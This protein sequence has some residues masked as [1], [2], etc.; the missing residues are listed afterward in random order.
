MTSQTDPAAICSASA[1]CDSQSA[2][3]SWRLFPGPTLV[4]LVGSLLIVMAARF[5][6]VS[7]VAARDALW[8]GAVC[9][10]ASAASLLPISRLVAGPAAYLPL[11]L[12]ASVGIRGGL[13]VLALIGSVAAGWIDG[14]TVAVPLS[15]WYAALLVA[16]L[17]VVAN[18]ISSAVPVSA[19]PDSER[20]TC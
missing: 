12:L 2:P 17:V 5:G 3:R 14:A 8:V 6:V 20:A 19:R 4:W 13:T 11:G 7:A 15:L 16:D 9:F 1:G 10:A 18:F